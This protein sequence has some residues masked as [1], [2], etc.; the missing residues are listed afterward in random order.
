[1]SKTFKYYPLEDEKTVRK[2]L[3]EMWQD[4]TILER[5]TMYTAEQIAEDEKRSII[6][7]TLNLS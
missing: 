3:Q 4:D 7:N 5:T 6:C 1:M 2:N